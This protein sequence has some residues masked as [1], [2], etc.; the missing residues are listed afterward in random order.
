MPGN[1]QK[2]G[3]YALYLTCFF[4]IFSSSL[5][6]FFSIL[7]LICWLI[8]GT[9]KNIP[10]IVRENPITVF[11]ITFFCLLLIGVF[12]SPASLYDS[13]IFLKKYRLLL[14]IPI[15]LSLTKGQQNA[16][17]NIITALLLGYLF[18]LI[19]AYLVNFHLLEPNTL[20]LMR[21]G[22]GFLVIFAYLVFQKAFLD[23]ERRLLWGGFFFAICYDIFFILNTRTGWLIFFGL[24]LL[25][26]V[27]HFSIKRQLVFWALIV[28]VGTGIFYTSQSFQQRIQITI[29]NLK[30]YNAEE[31]NSRTSVGLRLDWYQDSIALIKE[32]PIFGYGTGSYEIVQKKLIE[33]TSTEPATDPHNEFLLTA[34]QIGLVGGIILLFLFVDPIVRSF[35][36]LSLKKSEQAFALQ[37]TVMFLF[38]GCLFNS[39]LLSSIPSHIFAFLIV[40]LYPIRERQEENR[41]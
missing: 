32:K 33:G 22:G 17:K 41:Y 2:Y 4:C 26:L 38:I 24:A 6:S 1:S 28:F 15:V 5:T 9:F 37:A 39:W 3:I 7:M 11:C 13:L 31:R 36:L 16:S 12:Y 14:Y 34:V 25:F 27:Q 40:A 10:G 8:S 30:N 23:K 18:V 20:S 29:Q 19:N 21:R 35:K